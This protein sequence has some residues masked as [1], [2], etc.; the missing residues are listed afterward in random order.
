MS[1]NSWGHIPRMV[2]C[3]KGERLPSSLRHF[4]RR[5]SEKE[6]VLSDWSIQPD[7]HLTDDKICLSEHRFMYTSSLRFPIP[8]L[9][10]L[11]LG[12]LYRQY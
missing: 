9:F 2:C 4:S 10:E 7:A 11:A 12:E 6:A 5:L 1:A 8:F 3:P